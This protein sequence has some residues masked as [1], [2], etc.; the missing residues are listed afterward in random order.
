VFSVDEFDG[1]SFVGNTVRDGNGGAV[2]M[3]R[4]LGAFARLRQCDFIENSAV[5]GGGFHSN[6][7]DLIVSDSSFVN[8]NATWGGGVSVYAARVL[9]VDVCEFEANNAMLKGKYH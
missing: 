5:R 2:F 4:P 8:N 6:G 1:C 7:A 3:S 9:E